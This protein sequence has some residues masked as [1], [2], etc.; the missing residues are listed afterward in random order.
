MLFESCVYGEEFK[1]PAHVRRTFRDD[2]KAF[3]VT[4][5]NEGRYPG[6]SVEPDKRETKVAR[7]ATGL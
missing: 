3:A 5:S 1:G 2:G 6:G 4:A 7:R